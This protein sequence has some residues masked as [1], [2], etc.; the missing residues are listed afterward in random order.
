MSICK[1]P[2]PVDDHLQEAGSN[3]NNSNSNN[4]DHGGRGVTRDRRR[5]RRRRRKW[6]RR[7]RRNSCASPSVF[8]IGTLFLSMNLGSK[9]VHSNNDI[10]GVYSDDD[11]VIE[12]I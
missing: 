10:N 9:I 12:I 5:K 1:R 7:R 3:N 4:N 8:N 11:V 6:R 2:V